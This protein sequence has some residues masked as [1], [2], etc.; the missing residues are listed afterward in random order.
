[1]IQIF[2]LYTILRPPL[3]RVDTRLQTNGHNARLDTTSIWIKPITTL[4]RGQRECQLE[5]NL[6]CFT[7]KF[8]VQD[9]NLCERWILDSM[10]N[11]FKLG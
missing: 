4:L 3:Q 2:Y 5:H 6:M 11:N 10:K 1:M 8:S 9:N 7:S